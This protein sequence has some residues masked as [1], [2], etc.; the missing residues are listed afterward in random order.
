[1][2]AAPT[3]YI[4]GQA[5]VPQVPREHPGRK[6][7]T[8]A[9]GWVLD[10]L[11]PTNKTILLCWKCT[12]RFDHRIANYVSLVERFGYVKANCDD[13]KTV[14]ANCHMFAHESLLGTKH[15]K[16]WDTKFL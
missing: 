2:S 3:I 16:C 13:C 11:V 5:P 14:L 10:Y 12:H 6:S 15:G 9:A 1:V 8:T 4:P 7:R